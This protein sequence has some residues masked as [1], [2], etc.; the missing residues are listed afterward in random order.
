M[1]KDEL[2]KMLATNTAQKQYYEVA[3]GAQVSGANGLTTNLWR[4]LRGRAFAAL[5]PGFSDSVV[6]MHRNWIGDVSGLKV[7]ELGSGSGSPFS[8]A[9]ARDA[10]EYVA[11]DLSEARTQRLRRKLKKYPD[12]RIHTADFLGE[13]FQEEGFDLIYAQAVFHHFE[14]FEAFLDV[15]EKKLAPGRRVITRDP[16]GTW[17]PVRLARAV[18]RPFQTDVEW[19]YPFTTKTMRTLEGRFDVLDRKG[20]LNR[21]KWAAVLGVV[22]QRLAARF[23]PRLHEGDMRA[24]TS[25]ADLRR[26]LQVSYHLRGKERADGNRG[27]VHQ[28]HG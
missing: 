13:D 1:A 2:S 12:A 24:P 22:S 21:S 8:I 5:P 6:E 3:S 19:E 10:R 7:L 25:R 16:V 11:I 18:Y 23:A 4:K 20:L 15:V 9:F 28:R 14:H 17:L 26:S 27:A